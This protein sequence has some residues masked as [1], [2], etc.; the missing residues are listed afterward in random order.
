MQRYMAH[1]NLV[2]LGGGYWL[3][4][5]LR[6][7]PDLVQDL[8]IGNSTSPPCPLSSF[9]HGLFH[10]LNNASIQCVSG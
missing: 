1:K 10:R 6:V 5:V 3:E 7:R 4:K 8:C 2:W 9:E